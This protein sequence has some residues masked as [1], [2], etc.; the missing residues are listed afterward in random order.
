MYPGSIPGRKTKILQ[1]MRKKK[2]IL[3]IMAG[4]LGWFQ[5][6]SAVASPTVSLVSMFHVFRNINLEIISNEK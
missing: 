1:A 5:K 4:D 3:L 2:K 6:E